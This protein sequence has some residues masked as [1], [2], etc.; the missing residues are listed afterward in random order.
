MGTEKQICKALG[1]RHIGGPGQPDCHGGGEVVEVK[2]QRRPVNQW[3]MKEILSKPWSA[4]R[5]TIVASTSG[6]TSGAR[7]VAALRTDTYTFKVYGGG[8]ARSSRRINPP[9]S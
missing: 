5:P 4:G 1:K 7:R 8:A 6:F 2:S 9:R 3:Q